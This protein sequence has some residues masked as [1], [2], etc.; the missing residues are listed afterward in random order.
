MVIYK[1]D[2]V[3]LNYACFIQHYPMYDFPEKHTNVK[4]NKQGWDT[5]KVYNKTFIFD[6]ISTHSADIILAFETI[7]KKNDIMD[8]FSFTNSKYFKTSTASSPPCDYN[9]NYIISEI[10]SQKYI[11]YK[12]LD[13]HID[14][15]NNSGYYK[16]FYGAGNR[17]VSQT[18]ILH[19]KLFEIAMRKVLSSPEMLALTNEKYLE[20]FEYYYN[21]PNTNNKQF[22][23]V[24]N[25]LFFNSHKKGVDECDKI[26]RILLSKNNNN[27]RSENND[28]LTKYG[29]GEHEIICE[30]I[31]NE[32]VYWEQVSPDTINIYV[33]FQLINFYDIDGNIFNLSLSIARTTLIPYLVIPNKN[34]MRLIVDLIRNPY[35]I[36]IIKVINISLKNAINTLKTMFVD[37]PTI[38]RRHICYYECFCKNPTFKYNVDFVEQ[39]I[40]TELDIINLFNDTTDIS[41][42]KSKKNKKKSKKNKTKNNNNKSIDISNSNDTDIIELTDDTRDDELIVNDELIINDKTDDT[43]DDDELINISLPVDTV[44]KYTKLPFSIIFYRYEY[45]PFADRDMITYML[46]ELYTNN[47]KFRGFMTE[48]NTVRIIQSFHRDFNKLD[49]SIHFNLIFYDTQTVYKS[50]VYH[51]YISGNNEIVSLTTITNVLG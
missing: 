19:Y 36:P 31:N 45:I 20:M 3:P 21:S 17:G 37:I 46:T 9:V 35:A 1:L 11:S 44:V 7:F 32:F 30:Y 14:D 41:I 4:F 13:D 5:Y 48:F 38:T 28:F 26:D 33:L 29:I 18:F 24:E 43:S 34:R 40:P 49:K 51:A 2:D 15:N 47:E 27:T 25:T 23:N 6:F 42:S 39:P 22:K 8:Y 10:L 12:F 16:L 50:P